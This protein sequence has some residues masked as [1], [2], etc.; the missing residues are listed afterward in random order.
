MN[1]G[2]VVF[3]VARAADGTMAKDGDVPWKFREVLQRF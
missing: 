1:G 2:E 3:V